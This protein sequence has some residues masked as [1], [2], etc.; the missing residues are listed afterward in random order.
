MAGKAFEPAE[1]IL[2]KAY[3]VLLSF[4][5]AGFFCGKNCFIDSF[6]SDKRENL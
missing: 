6:Y 3:Y 4:V 5:S 2:N 1:T